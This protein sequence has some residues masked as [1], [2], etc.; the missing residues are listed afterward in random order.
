[1]KKN[2]LLAIALIICRNMAAQNTITYIHNMLRDTDRYMME[3]VEYPSICGEGEN[4]IWDFSDILKKGEYRICIKGDS[5]NIYNI[6]SGWDLIG[7]YFNNDTILE[8]NYAN[9]LKAITYEEP[10]IRL[11]FPLRF[12]D[13]H[14]KHFRGHGKYCEDHLLAVEGERI[15]K[16]DGAGSLILSENDT[17]HNALRVF[18]LTTSSYAMDMDSIALDTALLKQEIEERYDWY[19]K[20]HRYPLFTAIQ[21]TS[22]SDCVPVAS[23]R[24]AYRLLSEGEAYSDSINKNLTIE[25]GMYETSEDL[26]TDFIDYRVINKNGHIRVNY[27]LKKNANVIALITNATGVVYHSK[28]QTCKESEEYSLDFDCSNLPHGH[29][30]LYINV[31]GIVYGEKIIM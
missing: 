23:T 16:A 24:H 21:R 10:K 30:I 27:T 17:L 20:G 29:Y 1:M 26:H 12:G 15:I 13:E 6:E 8:S 2:I 11:L 7:T 3:E 19:V 31:N 4:A 14:C 5:N 28:K 25:N 18:T 9:R 22:Y